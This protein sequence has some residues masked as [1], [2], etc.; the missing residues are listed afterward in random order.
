MPLEGTYGIIDWLLKCTQWADDNIIAPMQ[1]SVKDA[2][3]C[4]D[5]EVRKEA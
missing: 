2:L 4:Q 5:E 1:R 3:Q